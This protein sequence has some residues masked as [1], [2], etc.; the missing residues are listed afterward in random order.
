MVRNKYDLTEIEEMIS[1]SSKNRQSS[2]NN[3][4][5]QF[6]Y[7]FTPAVY[8]FT[9]NNFKEAHDFALK[10][11]QL[12]N[13]F[14]HMKELYPDLFIYFITRK[15]LF[16]ERL[17]LVD[18]IF[19]NIDVGNKFILNA[20]NIDYNIKSSFYNFNLGMCNQ[21]A[22]YQ[23]SL[24]VIDEIELFRKT[25]L[26]KRFVDSEEQLYMVTLGD[27][28]FEIGDYKKANQA[29]NQVFDFKLKFRDDIYCFAHIKSILI[30]Y[31][32]KNVELL[33]YKI[34][35]TIAFLKKQNRLFKTEKLILDFIRKAIKKSKTTKQDYQTLKTQL[36]EILE[37]PLEK[38]ILNYF[39]F[40]IW[41]DSKILNKNFE[42]IKRNKLK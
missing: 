14:P 34:K 16:E 9:N 19:K 13:K 41:L 3:F 25:L 36:T 35:T 32:L 8:A 4:L 23:R 6:Y 30:H 12:W 2:K 10:I 20:S 26:D 15:S 37:D 29:I 39:D 28:Y 11:E 24:K 5:A 33:E 17:G 40:L 27:T 22:Q 7:L 31:E 42:T 1:N 38:N 21:Y 18:S